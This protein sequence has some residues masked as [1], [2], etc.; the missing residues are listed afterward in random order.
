MQVY[1]SCGLSRKKGTTPTFTA[2]TWLNQPIYVEVR[3][4]CWWPVH[5]LVAEPLR[6]CPG[7]GAWPPVRRPLPVFG[8][9]Q[10]N[11][12]RVHVQEAIKHSF[13]LTNPYRHHLLPH[14]P[15]QCYN[16]SD[17]GEFMWSY[18]SNA[19]MATFMTDQARHAENFGTGAIDV[20]AAEANFVA[21]SNCSLY[22]FNSLGGKGTP[23]WSWT[24]P[25]C[26][27][28]LLYDSDRYVDFSDDGSTVAFAGFTGT[29]QSTQAQLWVL[30]GQTG[31]LRFN[32]NLGS[33]QGLGG[34]V[35]VSENGT[36]VAWTS[37]DSVIILNGQ[38]G[39]IRDTV[40]MNW[41]AQA[42]VSDNGAYVAFGGDD[43]AYVYEWNT[44]NMQYVQ[45]YK[46]T[47]PTGTWYAVS[48]SMSSD[49]T[50]TADGEL[51][52]FGFIDETSLTARL[53]MVSIVTGAVVV[54][55]TTTT[56]KQLQTNPTVRMDGNYVGMSL[57][58]DNDDVPTAMV[59]KAGN[60]KPV[61]SYTTPGS[62]FGVDFLVD[63]TASTPSNDVLYFSVS[64]KY[65]LAPRRMCR[66]MPR[67]RHVSNSISNGSFL[68]LT[69]SST[70]KIAGKHT[71]ANVMGNGGDAYSWRID[72]PV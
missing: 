18:G 21:P 5:A 61:F 26:D 13:C 40:Q 34:P 68:C 58:G 25:N 54:D 24:M 19:Q 38:T 49:G 31:K 55:Y 46:V 27:S 52:S 22:A 44:T 57:W 64:G 3:R 14:S 70:Q 6:H 45:K 4:A 65:F 28:S 62:M 42:M 51:V 23:A 71:P 11:E 17:S 43:A 66:K 72:V 33:G 12:E 8:P 47:P 1:T 67:Q 60:N 7:G 39:A 69:R 41:N 9:R 32:K 53:M 35:Q 36:Y 15:P 2:A 20:I 29:S 50:G 10:T 16:A 30:D 63:R 56:N 48:T 37:G 59:F